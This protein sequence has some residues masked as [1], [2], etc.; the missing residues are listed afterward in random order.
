MHINAEQKRR[1][2]IK[3]GFDLLR[4]LIPTLNQNSS[5]KISKAALLHKGGDYL[6]Q[7]K[8]ER[9]RLADEIA[10]SRAKVEALSS[11]IGDLHKQMAAATSSSVVVADTYDRMEALFDAHVLGC[12]RHNWKYWAFAQM[13]HPLLSS[14]Q[15]AVNGASYDE[16]SRSA[17]NWMDQ[18]A[19]Q[20]HLRPLLVSALVEVTKRTDMLSG[21]EDLPEQFL[22]QA[23]R[24]SRRLRMQRQQHEQEAMEQQQQQ[25]SPKINYMDQD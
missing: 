8:E 3:N 5:V 16:V 13:M 20:K 18:N 6:V 11:A 14:Y 1:G 7:L 25:L 2:S 4:S 21:A 15:A 22:S 9:R 24:G 17:A 10:A 12:T 19:Q 23:A